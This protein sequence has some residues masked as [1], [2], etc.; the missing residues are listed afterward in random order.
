MAKR[1]SI[2]SRPYFFLSHVPNSLQSKRVHPYLKRSRKPQCLKSHSS[3]HVSPWPYP[4]GL[5]LGKATRSIGGTEHYWDGDA[6]LRQAALMMESKLPPS[7]SPWDLHVT[8]HC[9]HR[10][11][12]HS[13]LSLFDL[14]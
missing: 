8:L 5:R 1:I 4:S 9:R 6:I 2:Y 3:G 14:E 11:S 13:G 7:V 12:N 10:T